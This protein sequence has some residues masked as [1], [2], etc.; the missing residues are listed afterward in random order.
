MINIVRS[1]RLWS[2]GSTTHPYQ[3]A[4]KTNKLTTNSKLDLTPNLAQYYTT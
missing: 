4:I 3:P 2:K 1:L